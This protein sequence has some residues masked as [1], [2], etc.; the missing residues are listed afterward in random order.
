MIVYR[1][2]IYEGSARMFLGSLDELIAAVTQ[3][4]ND[5][6]EAGVMPD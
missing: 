6:D 5:A 1:L 2:E 3:E 4:I